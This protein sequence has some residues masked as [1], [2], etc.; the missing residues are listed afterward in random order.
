MEMEPIRSSEKSAIKTRT[1]GNYPKKTI[2]RAFSHLTTTRILCVCVKVNAILIWE[3]D[4]MKLIGKRNVQNLPVS[5]SNCPTEIP[6][7][8]AWL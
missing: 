1:P 4:G 2:H 3:I 5:V 8:I 7:G 6:H